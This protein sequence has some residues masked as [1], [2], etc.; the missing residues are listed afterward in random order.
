M[1]QEPDDATVTQSLMWKVKRDRMEAAGIG[2]GISIYQHQKNLNSGWDTRIK[3]RPS[4]MK[5]MKSGGSIEARG[6][7]RARLIPKNKNTIKNLKNIENGLVIL[8][9]AMKNALHD[10]GNSNVRYARR[11]ILKSPPTGRW[12][13]IQGT[14]HHAS[15]PGEPPHSFTGD[16]QKSIYYKVAGNHRVSLI[17]NHHAAE[18]LEYGHSFM[19][20][21]RPG[22]R[23]RPFLSRTV[24][25]RKQANINIIHNHIRMGFR[26][27]A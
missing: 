3:K 12:Y 13:H 17:S 21:T 1:W 16:L 18:D 8:R 7:V 11:L 27:A 14:Y 9:K 19:T 24:R 6:N 4:L 20:G 10:I 26:R 25:D 22:I 15:A 23:P 2:S 5:G